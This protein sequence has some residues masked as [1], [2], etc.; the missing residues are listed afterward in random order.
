MVFVTVQNLVGIGAVVENA[1]SLPFW[2]VFGGS[3]PLDGTQL[4]TNLP[5][6]KSTRHNGSSYVLIMLVTVVVSS[7]E[8]AL[9]KV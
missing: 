4:S 1:Y 5:K 8:T 9:K 3:D 2:V 7:R 6:I